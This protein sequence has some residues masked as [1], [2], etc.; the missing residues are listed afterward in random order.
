MLNMIDCLTIMKI[1]ITFRKVYTEK[2]SQ[3]LDY[4]FSAYIL[5]QMNHALH[6]AGHIA[7]SYQ[8]R[9]HPETITKIY[10]IR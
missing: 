9:I 4:V 5:S 6:A 10:F 3:K 1:S 7:Q 2:E 8:E